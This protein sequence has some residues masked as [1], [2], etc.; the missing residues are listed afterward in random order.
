MEIRYLYSQRSRARKDGSSSE[1][2][3]FNILGDDAPRINFSKSSLWREIHRPNSGSVKREVDGNGKELIAISL[4]GSNPGA[5]FF[6]GSV[7]F[8]GEEELRASLPRELLSSILAL[9]DPR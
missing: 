1:R 6:A 7:D 9:L 2:I 3:S 8:K 5:G 4:R